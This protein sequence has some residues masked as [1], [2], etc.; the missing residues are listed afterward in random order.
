[1]KKFQQIIKEIA[2]ELDI[3]YTFL[4]DDYIIKLEKDN[5]I[6]FI[7]A[8][9]F[10]LNDQG[11]SLILDDKYAFYSVLK[12]LNIKTV[13]YLPIYKNYD[14]KELIKYLNKEKQVIIKSNNGTCGSEVFKIENE[15]DLFFKID[16]LLTKNSPVLIS[17]YYDIRNEYRLIVLNNEVKL[18]YGKKRPIIIGNGEK[19]IKEL[20][21]EFNS[22]YFTD[23][24]LYNLNIEFDKILKLNEKLEIDFKFNLSKGAILFFPDDMVLNNKL[25]NI[26]LSISQELNIKFASID[27]IELNNQELLVLEANSGIMMDNFI[28][29]SENGYLDAKCI[30]KEAILSLFTLK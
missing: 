24:N 21:Q 13:E 25:K 20:L 30:Y 5:I 19:T 10:P 17:P 3:R 8:Y 22:N 9:K 16:F 11:I 27:I 26:A 18:L 12:N 1:M 23:S 7:Y 29:L 4:S 15:A 14:K 2:L 6:K 28:E